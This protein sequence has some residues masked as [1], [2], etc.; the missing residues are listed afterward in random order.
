[1][2][3]VDISDMKYKEN[4]ETVTPKCW[5]GNYGLGPIGMTE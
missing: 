3:L 2:R 4:K 1:M 5:S